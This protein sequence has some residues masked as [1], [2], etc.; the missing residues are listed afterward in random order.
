MR[1]LL[2]L[3]L[4]NVGFV[5][6]LG[7]VVIHADRAISD[8]IALA[9]PYIAGV[10]LLVLGSRFANKRASVITIA[11]VA[12]LLFLLQC[13]IV[14]MGILLSP[15]NFE[16]RTEFQLLLGAVMLTGVTLVWWFTSAKLSRLRARA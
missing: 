12:G 16:R 10:W 2:R 13:A 15:Y 9:L 7:A 14:G 3:F 11:I 1:V 8:P 4:W 6:C 5:V